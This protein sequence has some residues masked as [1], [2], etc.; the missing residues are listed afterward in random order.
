MRL[1]KTDRAILKRGKPLVFFGVL[2]GTKIGMN[3]AA[4]TQY[5]NFEAN[6]MSTK[7]IKFLTIRDSAVMPSSQ[8]V[9]YGSS[10]RVRIFETINKTWHADCNA[11][12]VSKI[13]DWLVK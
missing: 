8:F 12:V 10:S 11:T 6:E 5:E 1:L 3:F 9:D 13:L 2:H 4:I 7:Y